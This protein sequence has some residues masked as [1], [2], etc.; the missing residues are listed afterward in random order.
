MQALSKSAGIPTNNLKDAAS[1]AASDG[2]ANAA[3][4][5]QQH[6]NEFSASASAAIPSGFGANALGSSISAA[7]SM[8]S[9]KKSKTI[10]TP[11]LEVG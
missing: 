10:L 4:E 2:L 7:S 9:N 11:H 3:A 6:V 5:S 8:M 1:A